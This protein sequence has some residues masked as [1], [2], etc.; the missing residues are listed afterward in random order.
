MNFKLSYWIVRHGEESKIKITYEGEEYSLEFDSKKHNMLPYCKNLKNLEIEENEIA[1]LDQAEVLD[2]IKEFD[3]KKL[4]RFLSI[5]SIIPFDMYPIFGSVGQKKVGKPFI[6][7]RYFL[8]N[9]KGVSWA[10]RQD[11]A[12]VERGHNFQVSRF[13]HR[14]NASVSMVYLQN[15]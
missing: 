14:R 15:L 5:S 3:D 8:H 9:I 1:H 12:A 6:N 2:G 4:D 10:V 11:R 7:K 13:L